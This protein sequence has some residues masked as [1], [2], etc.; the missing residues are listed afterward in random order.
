MW[1]LAFAITISLAC[2]FPRIRYRLN[3]ER[4]IKA[5]GLLILGVP[6]NWIERQVRIKAETI[7]R[8]FLFLVKTGR[9]EALEP[10]RLRTGVPKSL[11]RQFDEF[12]DECDCTD[13]S[14][15]P[16]RYRAEH[17]RKTHRRRRKTLAS[18]ASRVL[19]RP[20]ALSKAS[21]CLG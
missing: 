15:F 7:K 19:G 8:H 20:V 9:W 2:P 16:F 3:A 1:S 6:L 13:D 4:V 18:L 12:V 10:E 14:V 5:L 17:F 21:R 11:I